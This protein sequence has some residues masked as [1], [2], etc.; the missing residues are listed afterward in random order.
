MTF[1]HPFDVR[2]D[3]CKVIYRNNEISV[4]SLTHLLAKVGY[5]TNMIEHLYIYNCIYIIMQMHEIWNS[6]IMVID[7]SKETRRDKLGVWGRDEAIWSVMWTEII[8][9]FLLK[10]AGKQTE[11]A[12][13]K[14]CVCIMCWCPMRRGQWG[15]CVIAILLNVT[16]LNHFCFSAYSP[17]FMSVCLPVFVNLCLSL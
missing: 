4:S 2:D 3:K 17:G 13:K 16:L 1:I 6:L 9:H 10:S 15:D 12:G 8:S 11:R 14:D 7:E 5:N